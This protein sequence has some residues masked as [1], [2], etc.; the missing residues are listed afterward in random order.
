VAAEL[1]AA[2]DTKRGELI[3]S[4][5]ADL[6]ARYRQMKESGALDARDAW[7]TAPL[8]LAFLPTGEGGAM[9]FDRSGMDRLVIHELEAG[10]RLPARRR[11]WS[12]Q[13]LTS[14]SRNW[15]LAVPT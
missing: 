13:C 14:F 4:Q 3:Q 11:S 9:V 7:S 10:C 2:N 8:V 6:G 12:A 1:A 5:I 15:T